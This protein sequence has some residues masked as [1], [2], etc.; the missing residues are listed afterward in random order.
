MF[1]DMRSL[2]DFLAASHAAPEPAALENL[3][4]G[5]YLREARLLASAHT[6]LCEIAARE[7]V[8]TNTRTRIAD[9]IAEME[10]GE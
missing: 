10:A 3:R 8:R 1:N 2:G 6:L 7:S 4:A 9:L 5:G